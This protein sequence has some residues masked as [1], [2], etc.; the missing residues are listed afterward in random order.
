MYYDDDYDM[1]DDNY[2]D[3]DAII[4]ASLDIYN[5]YDVSMEEAVDIAMEKVYRSPG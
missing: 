4:E 3:D 1:Y 5:E 2:D